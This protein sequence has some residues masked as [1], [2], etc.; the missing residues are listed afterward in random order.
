MKVEIKGYGTIKASKS[1]LNK[2]SLALDVMAQDDKR[3]ERPHASAEH[4]AMALIIYRALKAKGY[5]DR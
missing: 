4:E 2:I 1:L 3:N 5:Y